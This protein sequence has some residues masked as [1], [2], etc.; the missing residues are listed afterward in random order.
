MLPD[1]NLALAFV[2]LT[3]ALGSQPPPSG[4]DGTKHCKE[5]KT[6]EAAGVLSIGRTC[7]SCNFLMTSLRIR[8]N[9]DAN[10]A[11][12]TAKLY[13]LQGEPQCVGKL[14]FTHRRPFRLPPVSK[15]TFAANLRGIEDE[16]HS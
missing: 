10:R 8:T 1:I 14:A 13:S 7:E 3:Y 6:I 2:L 11:P 15:I 9:L 5:V 12:T 4:Q 16:H